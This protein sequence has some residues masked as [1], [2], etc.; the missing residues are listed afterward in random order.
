[1]PVVD[2]DSVNYEDRPARLSADPFA[3]IGSGES[4]ARQVILEHVADRTPHRHPHSEEVVY[5]A[6][7]RGKVWI[8]GRP[9]PLASGSWVRIPRGVAHATVPDVGQTMSLICFFPHGD[10]DQNLEEL[11]QPLD[12]QHEEHDDE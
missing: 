8:D 10:L 12:H 6:A 11:D 7:G 4:S 5:V 3:A 1:M 9:H 2:A